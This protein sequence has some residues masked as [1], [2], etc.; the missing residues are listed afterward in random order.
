MQAKFEKFL[1]CSFT[2][3][4]IDGGNN[5]KLLAK[6]TENNEE[7]DNGPGRTYNVKR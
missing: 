4:R 5:K 7:M 3:S 1:L 2:E 6:N